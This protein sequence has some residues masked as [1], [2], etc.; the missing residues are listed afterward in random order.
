MKGSEPVV[1]RLPPDEERSL[2]LSVTDQRPHTFVNQPIPHMVEE[3]HA[4]DF[5]YFKN[6]F[7]RRRNVFLAILAGFVAVVIGLSIMSPKTY[8]TTAKLIVGAG[9]NGASVQAADATSSLPV[10]NA[11]AGAA[12]VRSPETYVELIQEVPVAQR[13]IQ[14]LNLATSAKR[15]LA[16]VNAKPVTDTQIVELSVAWSDAATSAAIANEF[17]SVF[18]DRERELIGD[19]AASALKFLS[20]KIPDAHADLQK[21]EQALADYER[22]HTG[23]FVNGQNQ[24]VVT[25]LSALQTRLAQVQVDESQAKAALIDVQSQLASTSAT[26][27][28][29]TSVT[30]NPVVAG[31]QQQLAQI[32][33]Q[34]AAAR[35]QYTEAHPAVIALREQKAQLEL[36]IA[37]MPQ[38]IIAAKTVA[39]SPTFEKLREQAATLE[40]QIASDV[41]Q[42]KSL[43]EQGKSLMGTVKNLP[44]EGLA[45]AELQRRE[46]LSEEVYTT[47]ERRY[48]EALIA[49]TASL[50]DVSVTQPALAELAV[51]HPS[52]TMNLIIGLLIGLVL[53][54]TGVFLV[55]YFDNTFKDEA[56]VARHLPLP[57]LASVPRI[58]EKGVKALPWLRAMSADAFLQLISALRYSSDQEI[59]TLAVTS[60]LEGDGKSTIAMNFAIALAGHAHGGALLI[61]ADLRRPTLNVRLGMSD[62]AS[63]LSDILVGR[64]TADEV[65]V[66]TKYPGLSA[67]LAGP[68]VPNPMRLFQTER[69]EQLLEEL[70]DKYPFVIVDTPALLT[71]F[72]GTLV[73][74]KTDGA[75]IVVAA[76]H[77]EVRSTHRA[78]ERLT[79]FGA[80]NLLGI[81]LNQTAPANHSY[82]YY[83]KPRERLQL[84]DHITPVA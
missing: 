8:T 46:K 24:G 54:T 25:N 2:A 50:S 45:L 68:A 40:A 55:E 33:E 84:V 18:V 82:G 27:N 42:E 9:G 60:P 71:V 16:A 22:S 73:A 6:L 21:Q 53:A 78:I 30:V 39:M 83:N 38:T 69:F 41:A 44:T 35:K 1:R 52:L 14:N 10:V 72:D 77:T 75:V 11:L 29:A 66:T 4:P 15:L 59:R 36:Q 47:L 80:P 67:I 31:L 62:S 34:L 56:D 12:G 26:E 37:S 13:V 48:N 49:R 57:V 79:A 20:T 65:V 63:G 7:W 81:V 17:A 32:N 61:D 76:G 28:A 51:K 64:L 5:E 43:T 3:R 74:S 23:A 70:R 58:T 19:Q